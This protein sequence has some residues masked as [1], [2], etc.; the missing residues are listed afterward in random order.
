MKKAL[1]ISTT[2]RSVWNF[3]KPLIEALQELGYH[4]NALAL[5]HQ[6]EHRDRIE[7]LGVEIVTQLNRNIN[8]DL[9]IPYG[10]K[11]V[12]KHFFFGLNSKRTIYYVTGMGNSSF[13]YRLLFGQAFIL[14]KREVWV[15]NKEDKLLF[16]SMG[17]NVFQIP[18]SGVEVSLNLKRKVNSHGDLVFIYIGRIMPKKGIETILDLARNTQEVFNIYGSVSNLSKRISEDELFKKVY[19][20]YASY[21][22][23]VYSNLVENDLRPVCV[24]LSEYNEGIPRSVLEAMSV[25][26]PCIVSD[27]RGTRSL[28]ISDTLTIPNGIPLGDKIKRFKLSVDFLRSNYEDLSRSSAYLVKS[29][30]SN[31]IVKGA[32]LSAIKS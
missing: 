26:V 3:R 30:Y 20:G 25:G 5:S 23:N 6:E 12:L 13:Y 19:H 16:E 24:Y 1:I 15:Q 10:S 11:P 27:G 4:V 9:V 7:S 17:H 2:S 21:W 18:G 28:K 31:D 8:Y 14:G 22:Y 29:N 32:Y